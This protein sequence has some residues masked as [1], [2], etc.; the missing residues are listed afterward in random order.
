MH[1]EC[2]VEHSEL[3]NQIKW[4]RMMWKKEKKKVAKTL[5]AHFTSILSLRSTKEFTICIIY[6]TFM[7]IVGSSCLLASLLECKNSCMFYHQL[8]AN[9]Y[10]AKLMLVY[11]DDW[12]EI[13]AIDVTKVNWVSLTMNHD[14]ILSSR[15]FS[16]QLRIEADRSRFEFYVAKNSRNWNSIFY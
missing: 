12:V 8:W 1:N 16:I 6:V 11:D 10:D 2:H 4:R 5:R 7:P 3:S 15:K 13:E 9:S 14:K